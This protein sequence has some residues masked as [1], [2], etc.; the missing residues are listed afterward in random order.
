MG[1]FGYASLN[2]D[3][4]GNTMRSFGL[5]YTVNDNISL[6]VGQTLQ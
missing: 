3:Y 6:N 1:A 4:E 5:G 2:E